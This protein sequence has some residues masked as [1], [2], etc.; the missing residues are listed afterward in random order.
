MQ[1][2]SNFEVALGLLLMCVLYFSGLLVCPSYFLFTRK[3]ERRF[4]T[5]MLAG[6]ALQVFCAV[7]VW[8]AV[9]YY[10]S[11]GNPDWNYAWLYLIPVNAVALAYFAFMPFWTKFYKKA[12][13][14][15]TENDRAGPAMTDS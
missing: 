1:L 5:E 13:P 12:D 4:K 11:V 9:G 10:R 6:F 15:S 2:A 7:C 3:E 14:A 8:L